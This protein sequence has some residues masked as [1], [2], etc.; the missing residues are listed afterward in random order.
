[1]DLG[2]KV[3]SLMEKAGIRELTEIQKLAM[4][5]VLEGKDLVFISPTGSGKTEAAILP[6]LSRLSS[7][8]GIQVLYI[9]P[10]RALNRDLLRRL[11][12]WFEEMGYTVGVRHGDTSSYERQKQLRNPPTLLITTPET[13][14]A[15]LAAPKMREHLRRVRYVIVDEIHE[16]I[17]EKRGYQLAVALERLRNLSSFQFIGLSATVGAPDLLK[18]YFGAE[19]VEAGRGEMRITVELLSHEDRLKRIRELA[20]KKKI[21]VFTNT[22]DTAEV[23]SFSLGVP[24][25]HGSLSKEVRTE[26]EKMFR[27][28]KGVLVATSSLELGIDIGDIDLV[29]QYGSP[30]Q[31]VRLVQRVG[32]SR[33]GRGVPEGLVLPLDQLEALETDAI[34]QL[35]EEGYLE[36]PAIEE[37]PLDVLAHQVAGMV[38]EGYRDLRDIYS[39][40]RRAYPFRTL[41]WAEFLWVVDFMDSIGLLRRRDISVRPTGRTRRYYY[42]NLSMIPDERRI[43]VRDTSSGK[44]VGTLDESFALELSPGDVIILKGSPWTVLSI[45]K[46]V[47]VE[48]YS[49]E[50]MVP[51]WSGELIPVSEEVARRVYGLEPR[52]VEKERVKDLLESMEEGVVEFFGNHVAIH[53]PLGS[54]GNETLARYLSAVLSSKYGIRVRTFSS[55]Y[56]VILT[57]DTF[58]PEKEILSILSSPVLPVSVLRDSLT[59]SSLFRNRFIQVARRFGLVAKGADFSRIPVRRLI[60]SVFGSPVYEETF[61]EIFAEKLDLSA[62]ERLPRRW[63]VRRKMSLLTETQMVK[64]SGV[65]LPQV[66]EEELVKRLMERVKSSD[67]R[68]VC[69]YCG[70]TWSGQASEIS[71]VCP[72]CSSP[73]VSPVY[74]SARDREIAADLISSFGRRALYAL[75]VPGVGPRTASR[76]LR[77]Q[78]EDEYSFFRELYMKE[79]EYYS[80]RRFWRS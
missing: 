73:R 27:E 48:P 34:C 15:V 30:R 53:V 49:G 24:V 66:P 65:Q 43:S 44:R 22:R 59:R 14:Q 52:Y 72:R 18:E 71:L 3:R 19:V 42:E 33:H 63:K 80:T 51:A 26:H 36:K 55:P 1:M 16:L 79:K 60:S 54:K 67:V 62:L 57:F 21:L 5:K 68:L 37:N 61:R 25:H 4:P 50:G 58:V 75:L 32:R 74:K 56:S 41:D 38:L 64:T 28:G 20:R 78:Y 46:E 6:V 76:V 45:D 29:I 11:R 69:L 23:L 47:L 40:V 9:T 10:L 31:V 35:W 12:W 7:P 8:E 39:T 2:D 77:M 13:L 17:G 70:A